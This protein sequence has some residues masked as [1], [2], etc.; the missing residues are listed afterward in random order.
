[1][2]KSIT[3]ENFFSF[4]GKTEIELNPGVNVLVGINASGKSNFLRALRLIGEFWKGNGGLEE[5]L[6]REW[7]GISKVANFTSVKS[8]NFK[9]GHFG[10]HGYYS[11][12]SIAKV[13]AEGISISAF[14]KN[15]KG[16]EDISFRAGK[17]TFVKKGKEKQVFSGP[18]GSNWL[19]FSGTEE[20]PEVVKRH[21]NALVWYEQFDVTRHGPI[22]R[23]GEYDILHRLRSDGGNLV[24]LLNRLKNHH[25]IAYDKLNESLT[26]VSPNFRDISFEIIGSNYLL[27]LRERNLDRSVTIEHISDGT[28]R[29]LLLL[30]ILLNPERGEVICLDEPEIGLHPDMIAGVARL[31]QKAAAEGTQIFVATH[32]PM[33]L[34]AFELEDII[35]FE[36]DAENKTIIKRPSS[37]DFEADETRLPGFLWLSGRIG[38]TRW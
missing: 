33:L 26:E 19:S 7:G 14:R 28:L 32:S 18:P 30:S 15:P 29:Y 34:N 17:T 38:G 37:D 21:M 23:L 22:R 27:S 25:A 8:E 24:P 10:R 11:E 6:I 36:K 4:A 16:I 31:I 5:I 9:I 35:V 3:I 2:I 1:M 20:D 12:I 13:G